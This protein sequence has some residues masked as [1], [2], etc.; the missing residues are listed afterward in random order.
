LEEKKYDEYPTLDVPESWRLSRIADICIYRSGIAYESSLF[1]E[2][3]SQVIRLGNL[4]Q[5]KMD[6]SRNPVFIKLEELPSDSFI[7]E[8]DDILVSQTGTRYKRDYGNLILVTETKRNLLVNQRILCLTCID[9]IIPKFL[10]YYG[11]TKDF[12]NFFFSQETGGVNQGN[13]G[14]SGIMDAP[15]PL[16]SFEEQKEIVKRVEK[17]FQA[18]DRLE[19]EYQKA[20][21]FLDRLEQSTLA[22]AFRG[23]LVPQ[24]PNDEPAS[25]LLERIQKERENQQKPKKR[26]LSLF[27]EK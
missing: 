9:Y 4:Y 15:F 18:I 3:G 14:I 17:Y 27:K 1:I 20:M 7:V 2:S 22:K 16:L 10:A 12:K 11:M 26:Q 25:L 23:E 8:K 13:V 5:G 19:Q 6:L 24:D 21:K